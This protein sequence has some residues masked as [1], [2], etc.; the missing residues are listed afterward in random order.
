MSFN[1]WQ[2]WLVGVGAYHVFFG[3]ALAFFGQTAFMD[4][5]FNQYYDPIFWPENKIPQG[6]A[7][8][9]SWSTSVLGAVV[10]SWGIFIAFL[11]YFP[12]KSREKWAWSCICV[13]ITLWF[14]VDTALSLYYQVTINAVFNLITL[15]LF[16]FPLL[17]TRKHF[18]GRGDG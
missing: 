14:V 18:F 2:K 15:A 5:L 11:G 3:L 13:A 16:V 4:V 12:F 9:K 8:F 10:A 1:F 17:L 6:A 7:H